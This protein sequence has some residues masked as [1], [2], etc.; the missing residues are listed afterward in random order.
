MF[1]SWVI[2]FALIWSFLLSTKWDWRVTVAAAAQGSNYLR[3]SAVLYLHPDG[4]GQRSRQTALNI[5]FLFC[6]KFC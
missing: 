1:H 2:F 3:F 6:F 4:Q 5:D